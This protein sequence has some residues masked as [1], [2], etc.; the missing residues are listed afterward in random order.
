MC[1]CE[2]GYMYMSYIFGLINLG[3]RNKILKY[4]VYI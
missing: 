3:K 2:V 1:V 4:W